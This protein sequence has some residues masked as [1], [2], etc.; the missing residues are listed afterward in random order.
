MRTRPLCFVCLFLLMMQSVWFIAGGGGSV[1]EI[2]ASSVFREEEGT[3]VCI[4]GQVYKKSCTS[5]IQMLYLKNNSV[6]D[7]KLLIY[8][9][10]FID[11]PIGKTICIRGKTAYFEEARNPGNYNRALSYAKEE[12]YGFIWCEEVLGVT[13]EENRFFN[14]LYK[15][16]MQWKAQLERTIGEKNGNVLSAMLLG[17]KQEMDAEVKELYQKNGIGHVLAISGLHI[18]FIGLSLYQ[19]MRKIG[20][21]YLVAGILSIGVLSIYVCMIGFSVSVIRAYIMLLLRIGADVTGRVY[22]MPTALSLAAVVT[23]GRQPMYLTDAAFYLSYGAIFGIIC[24]LPSLQTLFPTKRKWLLACQSSLA[25]NIALFPILLWYYFEFPTYSVMWNIL[26]IPL[27]SILIGFGLAGS[28]FLLWLKPIGTLCMKVCSWI[29]CLFEEIGRMGSKMPFARMVLGQ[30]R[31]WQ[32]LLYYVVLLICMFYICKCQNRSTFQKGKKY[33][34]MVFLGLLFLVTYRPKGELQITM[35]DVGQGD[36]IYI[37]GPKGTTY[38]ID[39]GSSDVAQ[40]E[41]YRIEPFLKSQGVGELDYVFVTHGDTDHYSGIQEMLERQTLGVRIHTLV[42]PCNFQTDRELC[43]LRDLAQANS[44]KVVVIKAGES[45]QEGRLLI[46]CLQPESQEKLFGN[47]GSMVLE[48]SY[49]EFSML[50]TGDVEKEGEK[51][52]MEKCKRKVYD[53]LKVAHHG[54]MYA[55]TDDFLEAVDVKIALISSGKGNRYGHPH[56]ETLKRLSEEGCRLY[57]TQKMG[58]ITMQIH[59]NSLTIWPLLYRL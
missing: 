25:V 56:E 27:M 47:A 22:D 24:V 28:F 45:I 18:S 4:Q 41:K 7:S 9:E 39:G 37:K 5:N 46:Y 50:C 8:D 3:T 13:G 44:T 2:P 34:C 29:L 32:V 14:G 10:N 40:V 35:L 21:P 55:T 51:L 26:V 30:L 54:S 33:L 1:V 11:I 49:N 59:G 48:V 57:E 31:L 36:G 42:L 17:E 12:I 53:V 15:W 20:L 58:A 38:L 52:L 16:K 19:L 23:I 6:K 43:D